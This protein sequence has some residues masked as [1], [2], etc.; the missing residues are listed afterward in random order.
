MSGA[1][2]DQNIRALLSDT[3]SDAGYDVIEAEDGPGALERAV[4]EHPDPILLDVWMPVMDGLEVLRRLKD[5]PGMEAIPVVLVTATDASVGDL[6]AMELGAGIYHAKP[7]DP[8]TVELA[9]KVALEESSRLGQGDQHN[10]TLLIST[11]NM[12]LVR[13]LEGG[14]PP[15]SLTLIEGVSSSAKS[16]ACY[17]TAYESLLVG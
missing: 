13:I 1:D 3:L 6:T 9:V 14:I 2:D 8:G 11:G 15:R 7:W 12:A 5:T 16:V 4:N 10:D 17:H